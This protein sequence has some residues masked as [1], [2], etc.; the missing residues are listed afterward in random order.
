MVTPMVIPIFG[1]PFGTLGFSLRTGVAG[2]RDLHRVARI[3][4]CALVGKQ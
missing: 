2:H 3:H 1:G 4:P